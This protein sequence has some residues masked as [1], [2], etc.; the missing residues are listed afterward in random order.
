LIGTDVEASAIE[1][2]RTNITNARVTDVVLETADATTFEPEGVNVI[3]TNP[4]MGRRMQR[5]G[6]LE[7]LERFVDHAAKILAPGGVLVWTVPEP[8]R[9]NERAERAGL[10]LDRAFSVDMGG[11]PAALSLH[12]KLDRRRT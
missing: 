2:A 8:R 12:R 9:I 7:L 3:V 11:F 4:P 10:V 5:G 6:H 1:S